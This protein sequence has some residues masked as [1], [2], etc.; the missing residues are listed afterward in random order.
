MTIYLSHAVAGHS[1]VTYTIQNSQNS[2][3]NI[4]TKP[5]NPDID[6]QVSHIV[7]FYA[8]WGI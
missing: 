1:D 5:Y 7:Y 2:G 6:D 8:F 4:H 3:L